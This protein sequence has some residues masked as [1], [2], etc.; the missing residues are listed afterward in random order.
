[1]GEPYLTPDQ[2]RQ[3]VAL[4]RDGEVPL[5]DMPAMRYP[6]RELDLGSAEGEVERWLEETAGTLENWAIVHLSDRMQCRSAGLVPRSGL[7]GVPPGGCAALTPDSGAEDLCVV[8]E[9]RVIDVIIEATL[10]Q[11][12]ALDEEPEAG[13]F[14]PLTEI[15]LR[16]LGRVARGLAESLERSWPQAHGRRFEVSVVTGDAAAL[17]GGRMTAPSMAARIDLLFDDDLVGGIEFR[18]PAWIPRELRAP[19]AQ[20]TEHQFGSDLA[21]QMVESIEIEV[22]ASLP[23]GPTT[24]QTLRALKPG[25]ELAVRVP[26]ARIEAEGIPVMQGSIGMVEEAWAV[27]VEVPDGGEDG[28]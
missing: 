1:M 25:M 10:G 12:I 2:V 9:R 4:V 8:F 24:L 26:V 7:A 22:E 19:I 16:L 23:L 17:P 21:L 14:R 6:P 27:S 20:R 15:D 11:V 5:D 13:G 28:T 3:L 18:M